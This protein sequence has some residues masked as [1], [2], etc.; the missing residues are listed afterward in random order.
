MCKSGYF[1]GVLYFWLVFVFLSIEFLQLCLVL[2]SLIRIRS[3]MG[4]D[5]IPD[6]LFSNDIPINVL[7]FTIDFDAINFDFFL[8][9]GNWL[10]FL[11]TDEH[12]PY[13]SWFLV[14]YRCVNSSMMI[15]WLHRVLNHLPHWSTL[16]SKALSRESSGF[17]VS[18]PNMLM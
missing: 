8:Y 13:Y 18:V 4:F 5:L 2:I 12:P 7:I 6:V 9:C 11:F 10:F 3:G 17:I 16:A 14:I 15:N 1:I